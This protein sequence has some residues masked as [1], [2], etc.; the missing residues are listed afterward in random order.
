M[1]RCQ[2]R[3]RLSCIALLSA[4]LAA[5]WLITT[6]SRPAS[7]AWF[8]RNDSRIILLIRFRPV[9]LRQYFLDIASPS[10][11]TSSLLARDSTVNNLSRLRV[12]FLNTHPKEAVFSSRF[13][14]LN[15][16]LFLLVNPEFGFVVVTVTRCLRRQLRAAFGAAALENEAPS[17]CGHSCT[18]PMGSSALYFARLKCAFH[19]NYSDYCLNDLPEFSSG[20]FRRS[21]RLLRCLDSVNRRM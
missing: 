21:A 16:L 1:H 17:L 4:R 14:F 12:D 10:L 8:C 3:S 19:R 11:V 20:F 5:G 6:I 7:S 2:W 9:A 18:E 13:V 15:R